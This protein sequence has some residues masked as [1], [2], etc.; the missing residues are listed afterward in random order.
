MVICE[1]AERVMFKEQNTSHHKA[2][3]RKERATW[4]GKDKPHR[5]A[6]SDN[7]AQKHSTNCRSTSR[8]LEMVPESLQHTSTE[9][10]RHTG[11]E[12]MVPNLVV[13]SVVPIREVF[14]RLRPL[15]VANAEHLVLI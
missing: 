1:F 12:G 9:K 3:I 4:V 2:E 7:D 14:E 5:R 15:E 8:E 11:G 13:F 10:E 6:S